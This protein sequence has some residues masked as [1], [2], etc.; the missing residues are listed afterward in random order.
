MET[1]LLCPPPSLWVPPPLLFPLCDVRAA[2]A[3]DQGR[4]PDPARAREAA[5]GTVSERVDRW[6]RADGGGAR[7]AL[8]LPPR[9]WAATGESGE[10]C[11]GRPSALACLEV[12]LVDS[13]E[14]RR[15]WPAGCGGRAVFLKVMVHLSSS[16]AKTT[17]SCQR[18][19][20]RMLEAGAGEEE[21]KL[22][23]L[24]V[25][26]DMVRRRGRGRKGKWSPGSSSDNRLP[27]CWRA[28]SCGADARSRS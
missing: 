28:A 8:A 10:E 16:P 25:G 6:P 21:F 1:E 20:T 23:K 15:G 12:D 22:L 27:H 7:P 24:L 14:G 13:W 2:T 17:W 5:E 4:D 3:G 9:C 19:K 18:T 26:D 11:R